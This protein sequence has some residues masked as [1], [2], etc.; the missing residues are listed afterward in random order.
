[1]Q[2]Y[3]HVPIN[4]P[5]ARVTHDNNILHGET[6]LLLLPYLVLSCLVLY[7]IVLS[8]LVLSRFILSTLVLSWLGQVPSLASCHELRTA[9]K[10]SLKRVGPVTRSM[11]RIRPET[12]PVT[13]SMKMIRPETRSHLP[14]PF[15][16][17]EEVY[18][19]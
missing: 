7:G 4:I 10:R 17:E 11:K 9:G 19:D 18:S 3:L 2:G 5:R 8:C 14:L 16:A 6:Y 1:M 15:D 12:R 13:R